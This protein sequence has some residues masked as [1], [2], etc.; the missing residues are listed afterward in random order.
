LNFEHIK[1]S[2]SYYDILQVSPKASDTVI[3]TAYRSLAQQYHPD[4]Y[5]GSASEADLMMKKINLAY[6]TLSDINSKLAYDL[7]LN[8]YLKKTVHQHLYPQADIHPSSRQ[9]GTTRT[10]WFH[11]HHSQNYNYNSVKKPNH[12]V[13][14]KTFWQTPVGNFLRIIAWG[15]VLWLLVHALF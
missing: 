5:Q 8:E 14:K 7:E 13:R 15:Y 12:F 1:F 11:E 2:E 3:K 4:K 6:Q 9:S 10:N